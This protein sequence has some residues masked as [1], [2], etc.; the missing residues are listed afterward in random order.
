MR[1]CN[2]GAAVL[3]LSLAYSGWTTT[4]VM[5][6]LIAAPIFNFAQL[7][8]MNWSQKASLFALL[9]ALL[10]A[11]ELLHPKWQAL[12]HLPAN[13]NNICLIIV[14]ILFATSLLRL[15][16][17]KFLSRLMLLKAKPHHHDHDHGHSHTHDQHKH[18]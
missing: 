18:D 7:K 3:S 5:L 1:F 16:P 4:A 10:G 13:L 12:V 8:L 2:L 15:G 9:I 11:I 17:R 14:A 6:P